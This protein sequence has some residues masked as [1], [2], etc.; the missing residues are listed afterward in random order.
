MDAKRPVG[1]DESERLGTEPM[2]ADARTILREGAMTN[3]QI[4]V[5][6]ICTLLNMIDGFDVL[7][8]SFT[9]PV[10]AK[11]WAVNPATL[12]VLLSAGLAGM[13]LGS[14]VLSPLADIA[15]RRAVVGLSTAIISIGMLSSAATSN[16]WELAALRFATGLGIGGLLASG[17][18][19]LAEYAPDRWRDLSISFMVVGYSAGAII[20]GSISA[21]LIAAFGWR[22]AFI[23]GGVCS[24]ALLPAVLYL[25]ESIDFLLARNGKDALEGVNA[26]MRRLGHPSMTAL[27]QIASE[28]I[29]T[30]AVIGVFEARFLKGTLLICLSYFMLMFSFYFVLSWTPKNLVDLGFTVRQGIFG[31]VLLNVGGIL[32]GL[33]FGYF[34][35]KSHTRRLAPYMF[36]ALFV[37]IVGFGALHEGLVPVMTGAFVAGFFLI[38]SMASLYAI[39]PQIYPA[40]VRNTG[41]GLAIGFGRLGAVV[42]P[43]AGGT[44]DRGRL[45]AACLLF[46]ARAPGSGLGRRGPAHPAVRR[47]GARKDGALRA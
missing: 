17:N 28:E 9:A 31:S 1:Y 18:T 13:A 34:A 46:G 38:G 4:M 41:T 33:A 21:Y 5:V 26:V 2:T 16:V 39:V 10:I 11:E 44:P 43:Y 36:V 42:G 45:A 19:L 30:R 8:I 7:A 40:R 22:A 37:S 47:N 23:F 14:L 20:G 15:G 27:P 24:T 6:A 29:S 25:P 3:F 35:G 12:G 32:G